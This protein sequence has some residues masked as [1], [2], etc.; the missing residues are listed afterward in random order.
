MPQTPAANVNPEVCPVCGQG[1]RCAM[2]IEKLTGQPQGPC[3]CT[4]VDFSAELLSRIPA[5]A[6]GKA[7]LCEACA[8][9]SGATRSG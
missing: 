9:Q 3:W 5:Q 8:T 2:E 7:C 6:R 4:Q 1:N